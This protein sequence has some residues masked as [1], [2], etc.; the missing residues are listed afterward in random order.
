MTLEKF[1][2][3]VKNILIINIIKLGFQA[4]G[5]RSEKCPIDEKVFLK[6]LTRLTVSK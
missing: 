1:I 3:L 4:K 5:T 2:E 6:L